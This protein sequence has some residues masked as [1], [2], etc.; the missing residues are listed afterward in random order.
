LV[1]WGRDDAANP[2]THG[3]RLAREIRGARFEVFE[4]GH[5]PAFESPGPF[6]D[7]VASFLLEGQSPPRERKPPGRGRDNGKVA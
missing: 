6:V 3:R 2:L 5:S 4:C 7:A 1:A